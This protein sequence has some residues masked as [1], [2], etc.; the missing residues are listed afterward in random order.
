MQGKL[1]EKIVL[2]ENY[3]DLYSKPSRD[4]RKKG[5]KSKK[6]QMNKTDGVL[7]VLGQS[8]DEPNDG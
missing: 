7:R 2:L 4:Y 5:S 6:T 1:E 3:K 8:C